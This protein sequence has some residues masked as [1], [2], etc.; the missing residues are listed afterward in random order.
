M[1][2]FENQCLTFEVESKSFELETENSEIF[3]VALEEGY[4]MIVWL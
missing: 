2:Y 1:F 4:T 3:W